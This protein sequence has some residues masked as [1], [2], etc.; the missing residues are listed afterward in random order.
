M[1][2]KVLV[3]PG[4]MSDE[5]AKVIKDL[6]QIPLPGFG[7]LISSTKVMVVTDPKTRIQSYQ[8]EEGV[9]VAEDSA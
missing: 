9:E 1:L 2:N 8:P 3:R 4:P 6:Q 7:L 5:Q